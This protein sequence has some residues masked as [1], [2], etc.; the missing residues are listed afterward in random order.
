[1]KHTTYLSG[2]A[3]YQLPSEHIGKKFGL[4]KICIVH[5]R[6]HLYQPFEMRTLQ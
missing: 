1:M 5:C 3:L 4:R 6:Y 2:D